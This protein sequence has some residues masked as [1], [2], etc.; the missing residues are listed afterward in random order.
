[1]SPTTVRRTNGGGVD[2]PSEA[3]GRRGWPVPRLL[4]A[5]DL[6]GLT[7]A[8]VLVESL[9]AKNGGTNKLNTGVESLVFVM[10]LPMWIFFAQLYGL[11]SRDAQR[12]GHGTVD[13]IPHVFHLVMIGTWGLV[14][15]AYFTRLADPY[16][17]KLLVFAAVAFAFVV[18]F[19]GAARA[20]S[21]R[22]TTRLRRALV[23]GSGLVAGRVAQKL[24][25]HPEYGVS[26]VGLVASDQDVEFAEA[27]V[28]VLGGPDDL[29]DLV[30]EHRIDRVV[31]AFSS[32]SSERMSRHLD[33]LRDS[34]I[35]ID[36][37]PRLFDNI[38]PNAYIHLVEGFPLLGIPPRVDSR[39]DAV[40]KRAVDLI[41]SVA[42][43]ML[44][45][46]VFLAVAVWIRLDSRGPV[47][48]RHDRVGKGGAPLRLFKFR[49]MRLDA[50][51]GA[52]YGGEEAERIF[53]DLLSSP[54]RILEFQT[55][56]KLQDDPRVTRAGRL[57]RRTSIDELPQLLNVI[58]GDV[59]LVGPRPV[60]TEELERY[61]V[62]VADLLSVKPGITGYWQINGRSGM[63]YAERVRLDCAYLSARSVRLDLMIM[64]KTIRVLF[65]R[66]GAF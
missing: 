61:G 44:L 38:G 19:R 2:S 42:A 57:L 65:A 5:A 8:F 41:V 23:L 4:L 21:R 62:G 52:R 29:A 6:A 50:C 22:Q 9:F 39:A 36:I 3:S 10:S 16:P 34:K 66:D 12:A 24:R 27:N 58:K 25:L 18:L 56:Y 51:R 35:Q 33:D 20:V 28:P 40:T 31:V 17:P 63:D 60:T 7:A 46:P 11:Y 54:E 15:I 53:S 26:V 49:T 59:S 32:E 14:F 45:S 48:Y 64:A 43:L 13:E 55:H 1:M 47:F 30:R 37:V